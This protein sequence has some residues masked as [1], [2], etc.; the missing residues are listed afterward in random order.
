MPPCPGY[1][2]R[3]HAVAEQMLRGN[4]ERDRSQCHC[5]WGGEADM[6]RASV[7]STTPVTSEATKIDARQPTPTGLRR[8]APLPIILS[9]TF[10]VTLDFFI[11]NIA[12][13]SLQRNLHATTGAVQLVVAG[14]GLALAA[15]LITAG[16]LGDLYGRRR[17][18]AIGL[19]LFTLTSAAC[20][21]APSATILVIARVVQGLAA[22]LLSPQVLAMLGIV[23]TGED[24]TRAFTVYGLV[25]G[26][27]AVG[28]QLI[29]GVLIAANIAGL[30]W[31]TCF[32]INVPVGVVALL[33]TPRLIPGRRTEARGRLDLAGVVL[34]TVGLVAVVLPL[35]YGRELGWPLWTW[36]CLVAAA[37]LLLAF[38][39][40]QRRLGARAQG[41]LL[42]LTLFRAR[43]FSIGLVTTLIFWAGM[44]SFFLV[45]A[46]YLQEGRGLSALAAGAVFSALGLGYLATSLCAGR[47]GS[48]L[49]RQMLAIGAL[50][51]A[52]GLVL[53]RVVVLGAGATGNIAVLLPALLLDGAG[54]GM[55]VAPLT[56]T[57]LAGLPARHASAAAGVLAT[58]QQVANA[59]GVAV[60]G[61][62]FYGTLAH[63]SGQGAYAGA[64]GASMV[65]LAI[66]AGA[67]AVLVQLLPRNR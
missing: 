22:S 57:V 19:A 2:V 44:A 65:Y 42:E 60:I 13:P 45:L 49:G 41:P 24:R 40:Y 51:M 53:L 39:G 48:R 10:M 37:P 46:L 7:T 64:F 6:S 16:R 62:I 14:Y 38:I 1:D 20:G 59:L 36:L 27:A 26:L 12:I 5:P 9:G 15:G 18:F 54:M 47:L 55:V 8:W 67:V 33:L 11:V 32:L 52:A 30:D 31:R 21:L 61:I 23:Y 66:L 4:S 50:G 56:S 29:G 34:V 25:L 63:A 43:A 58:M 17:M 3:R 28:G 35:I